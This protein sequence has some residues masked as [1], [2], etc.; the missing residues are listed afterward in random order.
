MSDTIN[1]TY[2]KCLKDS[3]KPQ[4]LYFQ[5]T[6]HYSLIIIKSLTT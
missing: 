6:K 1:T 4:K 5:M 3:R 2:L